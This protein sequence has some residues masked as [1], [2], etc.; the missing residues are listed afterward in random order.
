M[1]CTRLPLAPSLLD[2]CHVL[3]R[4]CFEIALGVSAIYPRIGM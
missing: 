4:L 1:H 3:S 2:M